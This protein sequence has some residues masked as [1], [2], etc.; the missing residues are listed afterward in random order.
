MEIIELAYDKK[1]ELNDE[2]V[3]AIGNF[4]GIHLGHREI[5][6]RACR[7]AKDKQL[8]LAVMSFNISPKQL[9]NKINNYY[10]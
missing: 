5:I 8:K 7:I 9:V 10:V 4:D 3:V 1:V 2:Y 6:K